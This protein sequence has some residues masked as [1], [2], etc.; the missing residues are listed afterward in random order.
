MTTIPGADHHQL[1]C[2]SQGDSPSSIHG[3]VIVEEKEQLEALDY[4]IDHPRDNWFLHAEAV[5]KE[6]RKR[7]GAVRRIAH[8]LDDRAKMMANKAFVRTKIEY[9]NL[10]YWGAAED[11]LEKL[12]DRVQSSAV[13]STMLADSSAFFIPSLESRRQEAAAVGLTCKLLD[14][15]GRGV[16]SEV[17]PV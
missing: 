4:T 14:G 12:D 5:A 9:G 6:A 13:S 10:I 3:G 16:L 8:M 17:Q 15:Q 7:L 2:R 1:V 11:Y